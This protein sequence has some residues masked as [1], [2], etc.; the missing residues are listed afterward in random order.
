MTKPRHHMSAPLAFSKKAARRIGWMFTVATALALVVWQSGFSR[1]VSAA[2]I[3]QS[4][5]P[6]ERIPPHTAVGPNFD[7]RA[8]TDGPYPKLYKGE[9]VW[10]DV[11]LSKQRI[12]IMHGNDVLYTMI[13]SSGL[14]GPDTYTPTGVYHIQPER[15]TWFFVDR[16]DEGAE[17]W[18]SWKGHG[19][20]LFHSV[21]FDENHHVIKSSAAKLG[22]PDSHGCFHL[23]VA[24]AKWIYDNIPTGTKVVIHK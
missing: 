3:R 10:I 23:T 5:F 17:Y 14:P 6:A 16:F 13:T 9:K 19:Q 1:D 20:Y 21:P 22:V 11:S 12:Y 2:A 15:G 7:W 24:D 4:L 18:V 8:P